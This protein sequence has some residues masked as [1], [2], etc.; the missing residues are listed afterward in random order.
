ME[1][2]ASDWHCSAAFRQWS[3]LG[4]E[5]CFCRFLR[6]RAGP[7]PMPQR[8]DDLSTHGAFVFRTPLFAFDEFLSF[9]EHLDAL[10][11]SNDPTRLAEA[12]ERDRTNLRNRLL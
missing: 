6:Y 4:I 3:Q 9:G 7:S 11:K 2:R 5:S 8:P 1:L 10:K 12:I